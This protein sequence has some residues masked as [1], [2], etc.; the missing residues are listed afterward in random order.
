M[1]LLI[2]LPT[3]LGDCVMATPAIENIIFEYPDSEVIFIGS[4]VSVDLMKNHPRCLEGIYLKKSIFNLIFLTNKIG[5]VDIFFSFRGSLRVKLFSIFLAAKKKFQ[6]KKNKFKS[7]HQ[8]EKYNEFINKSLCVTRP[9]NRL[10]IYKKNLK[11]KP[12]KLILGINP[13][14]SYGSAKCWPYENFIKV[15][16]SLSDRFDILIFGGKDE[17][18][19]SKKIEKGLI[20][21]GCKNFVNLAGKTSIDDLVDKISTLSLFITGDSGPMHIASAF[22]IPTI[23]IFGPTKIFETSPWQNPRSVILKKDLACQPCMKRVC[24]LGHHN[25]MKAINSKDVI[26]S[27]LRLI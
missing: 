5:P 25:C 11:Q 15:A 10:K 24:P 1:K 27:A 26:D 8:V 22:Q 16:I 7:G 17:V 4:K 9:P 18:I 12:N 23:A 6:Y 14:A 3:W 20:K 19:L 21:F 13:G 2:E